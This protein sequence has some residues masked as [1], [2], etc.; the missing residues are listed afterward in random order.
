[1]I[2]LVLFVAI[3]FALYLYAI[4]PRRSLKDDVNYVVGEVKE[5]FKK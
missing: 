2:N 5:I 1:M 4:P 3:G